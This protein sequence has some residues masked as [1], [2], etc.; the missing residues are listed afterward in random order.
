MPQLVAASEVNREV[1][2]PDWVY[3]VLENDRKYHRFWITKGLGS[4]GTYGAAIW[5]YVMCLINYRSPISWAIA[6]TFQ[7]V[8]D[9]LMP[10]M[11]EVMQAVFGL[12]EGA[13]FDVIRSQFPRIDL[14]RNKQSILFKSANR[15]ERFVGPSVSHVMGTEPGLW[16]REAYQKSSARLR[17]PKAERLQYLLEGSPEGLGNLFEEEANFEEGIDE[18]NNR[19]RIIL[20]T[21]DNPALGTDYVENLKKA[22]SYDPH[23]LESYIYG[24]FVAFTKGTGYWEFRHSRNTRLDMKASP[25][26]PLTITWDWNHTP[27]AWCAV[28]KQLIWT[29][30]GQ[31]FDRYTVLGE[32]TGKYS[33]IM[34]ACAE[35]IAQFP[36]A[37]F[38]DTPIE[39]DGGN[40]GY[41]K[42]HLSASC[43]FDQVLDC[44]KKYYRNV[45][46]VASRAAPLIKDRLQKH[47]ALL[48]YGY[49]VIAP[50]CR[51][52]IK[53]HE[54]TNL[55]QGQWK[56]EKKDGDVVT[57][58]ADGLGYHLFR[59]TKHL[60]LQN[61]NSKQIYGFN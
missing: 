37:Q 27:L 34:D 28:Q 1:T 13:D 10:T 57:H 12:H 58:W 4:G 47:N 49:L 54:Q 38:G 8:A 5:H 7:Q 31:K 50:W 33:G 32:S 48:A 61:P 11:I 55:V 16:K 21:H 41:F 53:S 43:A 45:Q 17:C 52:T 46:I 36:P 51:N 24:K 15:P 20:W 25:L 42:S 22:Y 40:D 19:T 60:D 26:L 18:V 39:I 56:I 9:T 14:K 6:P 44:L 30:G 3:D 59:V 35:F 2:L 29:R 23:K